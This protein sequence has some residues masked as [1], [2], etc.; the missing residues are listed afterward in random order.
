MAGGAMLE[1][2]NAPM[3]TLAQ[4]PPATM[5][6]KDRLYLATDKGRLF[7]STGAAWV[8]VTLDASMLDSGI[9]SPERL[10]AGMPT[11]DAVL[12]PDGWRNGSGNGPLSYAE[13]ELN[14]NATTTSLTTQNTYYALSG[15]WA[16]GELL[17]ATASTAGVITPS[18]GGEFQ[19]ICTVS[20]KQSTS[21]SNTFE[22]Q[23]FKNNAGFQT[24][25]TS[26]QIADQSVYAITVN[27]LFPCA[28]SDT[29]QVVMRCVTNAAVTVTVT[30]ANFE[31]YQLGVGPTGATGPAGS[32]GTTI[33]VANEATDT[34]CF[35]L[36]V[37]AATGDLGPKTNAN[38]A[39]NSSTNL[40]TLGGALTVGTSNSITCGTIELGAASDTTVSRASAGVLAVEGKVLALIGVES[41]TASG[42]TS[43]DFTV[44]SDAEY[45]FVIDHIVPATDGAVFGVRT[46]TDAGSTYDAGANDYS[47][48]QHHYYVGGSTQ[49]ADDG[50]DMMH[51]DAGSDAANTDFGFSGRLE[52]VGVG[53]G[54][55]R[56]PFYWKASTLNSVGTRYSIE[57][58]GRREAA[59][60]IDRVRFRFSAGN[61]ASGKITQYRLVAI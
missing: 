13:S 6:N 55:Q 9:L 61:I 8:P 36:F 7:V 4:R 37:T 60:D 11:S 58:A 50:N 34:T 17:N 38:L 32:G 1:A 39:F 25:V 18:Q 57:G 59:A 10:G 42:S 12:H 15:T 54:T 16:T 33:T 43:L 41:Q 40:L 22:F 27:G 2:A 3:G 29:L 20:F 53:S 51:L 23:I 52:L 35:P 30:E 28:A 21:V 14:A 26:I 24:A 31:V 19:A 47:Y 45:L 5:L 48:H 49:S 44:T 56:P 46:S